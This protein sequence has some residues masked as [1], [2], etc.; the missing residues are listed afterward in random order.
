MVECSNVL[1]GCTMKQIPIDMLEL[2]E[3]FECEFRLVTCDR[4]G[5]GLEGRPI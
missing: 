5:C 4:E 1:E 3:K 2:H